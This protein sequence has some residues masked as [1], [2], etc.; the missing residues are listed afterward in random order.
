MLPLIWKWTLLDWSTE[1]AHLSSFLCYL[2]WL[3]G[4]PMA[5]NIEA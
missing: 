3:L 4:G 2:A 5:E 1:E